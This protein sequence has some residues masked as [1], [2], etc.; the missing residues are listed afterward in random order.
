M[1]NEKTILEKK[2]NLNL[3]QLYKTEQALDDKIIAENEGTGKLKEKIFLLENKLRERENLITSM[4]DEL[5][6]YFYESNNDSKVIFIAEPDKYNLELYNELCISKELYIKV[7]KMLSNEKTHTDK[8]R[9]TVQVKLINI[10]TRRKNQIIK[11][12]FETT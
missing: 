9:S 2:V 8:L 7:S 10:G 1:F 5:E 12:R 6:K 3:I 11:E 4:K